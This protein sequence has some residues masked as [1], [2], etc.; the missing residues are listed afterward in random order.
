MSARTAQSSDVKLRENLSEMELRVV[1]S[2]DV[3]R[4]RLRLLSSLLDH[5]TAALNTAMLNIDALSKASSGIHG[6][7]VK[8][9]QAV[10]GMLRAVTKRL[11]ALC[12]GAG[13]DCGHLTALARHCEDACAHSSTDSCQLGAALAAV[14]ADAGVRGCY[15]QPTAITFRHTA[16]TTAAR[17]ALS[18]LHVSYCLLLSSPLPK[19]YGVS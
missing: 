13:V 19:W 17:A 14:G 18:T 4:Y 9:E 1:H 10:R 12:C 7:R 6:R 8:A 3:A 16:A 15:P 11:Q 5:H 2:G